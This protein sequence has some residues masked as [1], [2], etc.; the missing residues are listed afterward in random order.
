[1]NERLEQM[2]LAH[3]AHLEESSLEA[4]ALLKDI[5][6]SVRRTEESQLRQEALI[7][8]SF[9]GDGASIENISDASPEEPVEV[10]GELPSA[11]LVRTADGSTGIVP[12][13]AK[14]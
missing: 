2:W 14:K 13:V 8:Q 6:A 11:L 5:A 4:L 10:I 9:G 3:M 1:M 12:K 7:T